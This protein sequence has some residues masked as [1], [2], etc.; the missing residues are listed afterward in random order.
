MY[1]ATTIETDLDEPL[2][3]RGLGTIDRHGSTP[4]DP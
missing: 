1:T 2:V 4:P 3:Q